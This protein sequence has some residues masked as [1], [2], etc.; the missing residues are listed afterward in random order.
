MKFI[1]PYGLKQKLGIKT[2]E[3]TDPRDGKK[4]KTIIVDGVEWFAQNLDYD[5]SDEY[6]GK[7]FIDLFYDSLPSRTH[8]TKSGECGSFY[9][10]NSL[11]TACPDGWE[12]PKRDVFIELFKKIT[13]LPPNEWKTAEKAKIYHAVKS[14]LS[15]NFCGCFDKR[16]TKELGF[17][18][19]S[20]RERFFTSTPASLSNGGSVFIFDRNSTSYM[21]DVGYGYYSVRPVRKN[22]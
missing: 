15:I 18:E 7:A 10:F 19:E 3:F 6:G 17:I 21:E 8:P 9:Q 12:I 11:K 4:Y 5:V 13:N 14:I 1:D 16:W 2:S 20:A 22:I